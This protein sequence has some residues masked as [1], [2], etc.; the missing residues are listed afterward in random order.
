MERIKE[1]ERG[2]RPFQ[3][4]SAR[5]ASKHVGN[6]W[7]LKTL[8]YRVTVAQEE[9]ERASSS[10]I[11]LDGGWLAGLQCNCCLLYTSPSPRDQA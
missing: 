9:V 5:T 11:Q 3:Q 6:H 8:S 10:Y 1:K 7:A 4:L 2:K